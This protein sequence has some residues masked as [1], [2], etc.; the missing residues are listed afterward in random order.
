MAWVVD[1][2]RGMGPAEFRTWPSSSGCVNFGDHHLGHG[3]EFIRVFPPSWGL[4]RFLC[5]QALVSDG[6]RMRI[7]AILLDEFCCKPLQVFFF[8]LGGVVRVRAGHLYKDV[9]SRG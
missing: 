8:F 3:D 2:P 5:V 1:K 9:K 6:R 4:L 7:A